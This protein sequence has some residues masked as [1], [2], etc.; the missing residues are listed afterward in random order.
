MSIHSIQ[1]PHTTNTISVETLQ[2]NRHSIQLQHQLLL[3]NGTPSPAES[4]SASTLRLVPSVLPSSASSHSAASNSVAPA[5]ENK[6]P[7]S[8]DSK[9]KEP[10][11]KLTKW[12]IRIQTHS[13]I[14]HL[15]H[16][17][18]H[19]LTAQSATPRAELLVSA[20]PLPA[21]TTPNPH[22][23]CHC[24][25]HTEWAASRALALVESTVP[26]TAASLPTAA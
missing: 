7:T 18:S 14:A 11:P 24:R 10:K 12:R 2:P 19:A 21:T 17:N 26:A 20:V 9:Q 6:Q 1:V 23:Q 22:R 4:K 16:P 13:P 3:T 5:A 25:Q 15:R 8:P